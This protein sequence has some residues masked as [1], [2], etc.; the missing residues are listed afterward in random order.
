MSRMASNPSGNTDLV[1]F[2]T[3][4]FKDL[5]N[6]KSEGWIKLTRFCLHTFCVTLI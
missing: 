4:G 2:C 5:D 6:A 1:V 3:G